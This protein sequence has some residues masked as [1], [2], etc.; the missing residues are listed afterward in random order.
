M[1]VEPFNDIFAQ[2]ALKQLFPE[3][4]ADLFFDALFGDAEEGTYDISLKFK[5]HRQNKL[6]FEL[7]LKQRPGKCLN[8]NLTYG[9]PDVFSR[10]PIINING[11]VK[12][13]DQLLS[14]RAKCVKWR[15]GITK[16]VSSELHIIP[17]LISLDY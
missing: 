2:D 9:L 3:D 12:D 1:K 13:I 4:R 6:E 17:L 16:E 14:R 11:L 7:R 15:L 10:H 8:C 5:E